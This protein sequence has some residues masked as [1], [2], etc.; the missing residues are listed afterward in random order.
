M[1][2]KKL[3]MIIPREFLHTGGCFK[4]NISRVQALGW[5]K[6]KEYD[7]TIPGFDCFRLATLEQF[8]YAITAAVYWG[9][10][11]KLF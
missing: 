3:K 5:P 2:K 11:Y 10:L 1:L 9:S 6:K 8:L 4:R 7:R